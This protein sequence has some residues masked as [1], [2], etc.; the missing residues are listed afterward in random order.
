MSLD[1]VVTLIPE[2]RRRVRPRV[3]SGQKLRAD[4]V[5][6]DDSL[7][8]ASARLSDLVEPELR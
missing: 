2:R 5:F 3:L 1:L 7:T 4:M 6:N 8:V